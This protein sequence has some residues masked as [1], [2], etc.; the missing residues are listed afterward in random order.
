MDLVADAHAL[1]DAA[2]SA[3]QAPA[4]VARFDARA[5]LGQPLSSF[6]TVTVV[7][8]G[9]ASMA[10]AGALEAQY[11]TVPF[12][13]SVVVPH[14]YPETFPSALQA[15]RQ[16]RVRTAGHPVPDEESAK[17]AHATL[18]CVAA[19]ADSHLVLVLLSGGG[20]ALWTCPPGGIALRDLQ[21]LNRCLLASGL[22]IDIMN[23]V[24]KHVSRIS[25]GRLA[26]AAHPTP[27][28]ALV[29][30][31]VVGNDL[32]S[33]A[34]GPTVGDATTRAEVRAHLHQA[35]LWSRLP[36]PVAAH[37]DSD[38]GVPLTPSDER[39]DGA[40]TLLLGSNRDALDAAAA[41][42][43]ARGYAVVVVTDSMA[44]EAREVGAAH[45]RAAL[46][47]AGP[48]A[49]LWSGE[50]TVT[51]TGTGRG[52]RNQ[53]TALA[54][55][56]A[57]DQGLGDLVVLCG[58]TDGIDGPTDAAG[59]WATPH[60]VSAAQRHGLDARA[61]LANNDAYSFFDRLAG[62]DD[63]AGGLLRPGPTHTNVMDLHV[64]LV[65]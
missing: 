43:R 42:A 40:H 45:A 27:I 2:V 10:M 14:G 36:A 48:T 60:T 63:T 22:P 55:A 61:H 52:G 8:A 34:S 29:L 41:E 9:K 6:G 17:A 21:V 31:D 26:A 30:S 44:G 33:I 47:H 38:V 28:V 53:E 12:A 18:G 64:A 56:L 62:L 5:V 35:H 54:A 3:V 39:L 4:V 46:G 49:L 15:P 32:A 25:G 59:A 13:G 57:L 37:L 16:I 23:A 24:R 51:L 65:A 7:G 50:P 58:G 1:Y 20:S 11:P 19:A